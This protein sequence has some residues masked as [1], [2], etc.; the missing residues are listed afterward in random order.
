MEKIT[1]KERVLAY[2]QKRFGQKISCKQFRYDMLAE[3]I[4]QPLEYIKQLRRSG[5]RI[6]TVEDEKNKKINYYQYL[7]VKEN[8]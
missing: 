4:L 8:G 7:G 2:F 3:F 5:F 6:K 1:Q